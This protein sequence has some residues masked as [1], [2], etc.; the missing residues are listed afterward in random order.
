MDETTVGIVCKW[1]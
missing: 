1:N